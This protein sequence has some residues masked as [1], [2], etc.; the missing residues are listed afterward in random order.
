MRLQGV[1]AKVIGRK[2]ND[3]SSLPKSQMFEPVERELPTTV[4]ECSSWV[5]SAPSMGSQRASALRSVRIRA[6]SRGSVRSMEARLDRDPAQPRF[7]FELLE[8]LRARSLI[9]VR[10]RRRKRLATTGETLGQWLS[11]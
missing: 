7:L 8:H 9:A 10:G 6:E 3:S 2:A 4:S 5:E 1:T 11:V